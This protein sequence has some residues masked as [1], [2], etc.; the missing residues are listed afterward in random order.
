MQ[1][2]YKI[3][4]HGPAIKMTSDLTESFREHVEILNHAQAHSSVAASEF[5]VSESLALKSLFENVGPNSTAVASFRNDIPAHNDPTQSGGLKE[6]TAT[7]P[8]PSADEHLKQIRQ[9]ID[10]I[11]SANGAMNETGIEAGLADAE[12]TASESLATLL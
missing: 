8:Q 7:T 2:L 6:R 3:R 1:I 5:T 10:N 12:A 4:C 11:S 9:A